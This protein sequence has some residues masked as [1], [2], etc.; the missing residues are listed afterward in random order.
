[1]SSVTKRAFVSRADRRAQLTPILLRAVEELLEGGERYTDLTVDRICK[2]ADTSRSTFYVYFEDK[3][4]L[5]QEFFQHIV[6]DLTEKAEFWWHLPHHTTKEQMRTAFRAIFDGYLPNRAVWGAVTEAVSYDEG[7]RE[8]YQVL[9]DGNVAA[10]ANHIRVGQ[11][12]GYVR[13][14][15]DPEPTAQWLT[16]MTATGL[17]QLVGPADEVRLE[18]L[19]SSI[20]DIYWAT[21]YEG[22]R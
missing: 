22:V 8:R 5:L 2:T 19:L 3:G 1:M 11:Q 14:E 16:W 13:K 20:V 18:A 9:M 17:H 7:V 12:A 15:V 6:A 10:V 4:F 21:L